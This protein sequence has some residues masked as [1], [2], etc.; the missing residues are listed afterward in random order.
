MNLKDVDFEIYNLIK[1]EEVR[2][3]GKLQM[4]P[5]EN[6]TSKAVLEALGSVLTNKYA[7]G[8]VGKRYYQGNEFVDSIEEL[9]INRA[10]EIFKVPFVNVQPY[11]GSPAN[12]AVMFAILEPNDTIL[13]L[14]LNSG[15]HL[16]HGHPQVTFSGKYFK[17]VQY[18][19]NE[20]GFIDYEKLRQLALE[21]KP[22]LIISGTTAYPRIIDFKK[23]YEISEEVGAYH[24]ADISH[25]LGLV[26][27]NAH[28]SPVEWSHIVMGTTHKTLKGPRGA[29][30]FVTNK[31]IEKNSELPSLIDK[32]VFP[33]LQGGPHNNV[34]AGIAVALEESKS[35]GFKEYAY[36]TVENAKE[37]SRL[38]L[39][40]DFKIVSG[41]T[42][43]H[44]IL[45]DI[46][47]KDIDGWCFAWALDY[48]GIV[49]NRNS[50]PFDKKSA[51][52]PSG[53]RLG[54]PAIT[55]RGLRKEHMK[56]I[57]EWIFEVS[58]ISKKYISK[59][60]EN[61]DKRIRVKARNTFRQEISRDKRIIEISNEIKE[62][63]K[64][65]PVPTLD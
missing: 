49:C 6:H 44:L 56:K 59:D 32:A 30:I 24:L 63:L 38:L 22:K 46:T 53:I 19:V 64:D 4:I 60:F 48:A 25:I 61:K 50:I 34:T 16:T 13:G 2:Q 42:D 33:G 17:S 51:F 23:I 9:A 45:I 3:N 43:N 18:E 41:G 10:K 1:Q 31:G 36:A 65:F 57:A 7:E 62:F 55:S 27:V 28:P 37:L 8:Y 14:S 35:N 54:T 15:G 40:K 12:T 39:E 26:A 52:Y 29:L 11:S 47:N 21:H 58:E 5:S 20:A